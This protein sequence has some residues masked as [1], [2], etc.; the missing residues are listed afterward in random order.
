MKT[1]SID[2]KT[3]MAAVTIKTKRRAMATKR[4]IQNITKGTH[5]HRAQRASRT[6]VVDISDA[7]L[8]DS[9]IK[10]EKAEHLAGIWGEYHMI[11]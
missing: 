4:N 5:N 9:K 1:A 10:E 6:P 7:D 8:L 11:Q 3:I 2:K